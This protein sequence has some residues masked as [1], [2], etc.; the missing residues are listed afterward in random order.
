MRF[1]VVR[2]QPVNVK[3]V[4]NALNALKHSNLLMSLHCRLD[5]T[6]T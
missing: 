5:E 4:G 3:F 6:A 2:K 1:T